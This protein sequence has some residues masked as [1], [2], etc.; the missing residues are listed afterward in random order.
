ME[1][2]TTSC[3]S[4]I[5]TLRQDDQIAIMRAGWQMKQVFAWKLSQRLL[6]RRLR[7]SCGPNSAQHCDL[8]RQSLLYEEMR[9]QA[10]AYMMQ[11][12]SVALCL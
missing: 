1:Q 2:L 9:I 3:C 8:M 11:D 7:V 4:A 10:C 6:C 5:V 12:L